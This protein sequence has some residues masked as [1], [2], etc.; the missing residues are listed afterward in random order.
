[1]NLK[2]LL[3]P[4]V[5]SSVPDVEILG[6]QNDSRQIK[7]G[8]VFF[9]YPGALCDGR[10]FIQ[11]AVE[12]GARAVVYDPD[13][14]PGNLTQTVPCIPIEQL[15]SKLA[16]MA[17]HFYGNP[18]QHLHLTGIT[19]TNGKTT[20]AY[21]LAQAYELFGEKAHYLGT[22]GHGSV[23]CLQVSK[24]TTPDAVCLQ[25]W[26]SAYQHQNIQHVCM[27]VS[28]HAL[29]QGRVDGV[30]FTQAIYTNLSHD[31]L[32][33]HHTMQ[34][35]AQ[36]KAKLFA[37]PHLTH[38]ILNK[39]D[40]Y[41]QYM[42]EQLSRACKQITYGL[43]PKS[44]IQAIDLKISMHHTEFT[45]L[46]PWGAFP[47]KSK[48][49]G[50]FN[51]YNSLA[52]FTSLAAYGFDPQD[53]ALILSQLTAAPGRM[54]VVSQKPCVIVDYAHTPDALENVLATLAPL[55]RNR[56]WVVFGCGGDRDKMKRPLMGGVVSRYADGIIVT[57]DNPR[58]ED[59]E[60]IIREIMQGVIHD[61]QVLQI[62]DRE[63]AIQKSL[64]LASDDDIILIAGKG[65]ETYQQ[66]GDTSI[67]FSDQEVVRRLV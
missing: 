5:S 8:D 2:E 32:D 39:D 26:L 63:E 64:E 11:K 18:S 61:K 10:L 17:S 50:K 40:A 60:Q 37:H 58:H 25:S 43:T 13:K 44:D 15:A 1:M 33:Y 30:E 6:I 20:I 34:A 3:V 57:S 38:A 52:V 31:H 22:L 66:L 45:V 24:N 23:H 48:M 53:I 35:Y 29:D 12:A 65:H 51:V 67:S 28:S 19:G 55:K 7:E 14:L 54:E 42:S 49:V 16:A 46:S 56:L 9:A 47:I 41:M 27:E 36:A 4:W 62:I 59:P 21:Q